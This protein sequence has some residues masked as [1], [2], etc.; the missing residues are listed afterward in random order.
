MDG[1]DAGISGLITA[2]SGPTPGVLI[3]RTHGDTSG[4][5]F[6]DDSLGPNLGEAV[7]AQDKLNA[8]LG[9]EYGMTPPLPVSAHWTQ[10]KRTSPGTAVPTTSS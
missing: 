6:T 5:L 9:A 1:D 4:D 10:R 3:I 7:A 2:L 8:K